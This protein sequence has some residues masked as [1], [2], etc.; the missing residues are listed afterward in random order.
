MPRLDRVA[1]DEAQAR[2]L[3]LAIAQDEGGLAVAD[4]PSAQQAAL[5]VQT[6][7]SQLLAGN[8]RRLRSGLAAAAEGL[9]AELQNP[10]DYD[11]T[12]FADRLAQLGRQLQEAR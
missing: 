6:L 4:Y 12:R 1:W 11:A 9:A 8:P 10:Y 2:R 5:A 7:V 3:L